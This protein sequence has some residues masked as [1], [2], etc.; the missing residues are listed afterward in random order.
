MVDVPCT[1]CLHLTCSVDVKGYGVDV[2]GYMVDAKGYMVDVKGYD[3]DVKGRAVGA[4]H[5]QAR[6]HQLREE[7]GQPAL[8]DQACAGGGVCATGGEAR[9][10]EGRDG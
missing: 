8:R 10:R 7:A 4:G 9:A 6:G 1:M 2:K 5:A 3:V